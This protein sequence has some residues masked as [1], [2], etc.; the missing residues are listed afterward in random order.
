MIHFI[1][2][3]S[4]TEPEIPDDVNDIQ[5]SSNKCSNEVFGYV[6]NKSVTIKKT[7]HFTD[8][9]SNY[10]LMLVLHMLHLCDQGNHRPHP[11]RGKMAAE[12]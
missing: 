12:S 9:Y 11:V 2:D 6:Q 3:R 4:M 5:E 1:T 8:T 10:L 7:Y